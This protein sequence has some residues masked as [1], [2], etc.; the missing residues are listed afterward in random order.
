MT[1]YTGFYPDCNIWVD[2]EVDL[3]HP[4]I[5]NTFTVQMSEVV[6]A[7]DDKKFSLR[8]CRD[9]AILL[10]INSLE[11]PH[12][13]DLPFDATEEITIWAKYLNF[14]NS[15]YLLLT[16]ARYRFP[17]GSYFDIYEVTMLDAFRMSLGE[18]DYGSWSG[19]SSGVA[20]LYG[21]YLISYNSE[22]PLSHDRS[23]FARRVIPIEMFALA[24]DDFAKLIEHEGAEKHFATLSKSASEFKNGN[25]EVAI[26]LSW[27]VI[28]SV[29]N[30]TWADHLKSINKEFANGSKRINS[31]ARMPELKRLNIG[32]TINILELFEVINFDEYSLIEEVRGVR[33]KIVHV[34]GLHPTYKHARRAMLCAEQL[35]TRRWGI[36][37]TVDDSLFAIGCR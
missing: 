6:Y 9:G 11:R 13:P 8:V 36:S 34:T 22:I 20:H 27:F 19:G 24:A 35:L 10:Q 12:D 2:G 7:R 4:D 23:F 3:S 29:I 16:S 21:R 28:E 5:K 31:N 26:T 32:T 18:Q 30:H 25:Y 33:N 14:I 17:P 1:T 37:L 15:F